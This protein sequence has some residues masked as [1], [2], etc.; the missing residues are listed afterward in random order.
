MSDNKLS[1]EIENLKIQIGHLEAVIEAIK[2]PSALPSGN[3]IADVISARL[4]KLD[5]DAERQ[6][7]L[8]V[9]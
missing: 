3:T 8:E 9:T 5:S 2:I 1:N 4:E 6:K 7:S